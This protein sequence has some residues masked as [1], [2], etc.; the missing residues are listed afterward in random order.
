MVDTFTIFR[1]GMNGAITHSMSISPQQ[2]IAN[3]QVKIAQLRNA[4]AEAEATLKGMEAIYSVTVTTRRRS[5]TTG[6]SGTGE[7]STGGGRQPGAISRRWRAILGE[8]YKEEEGFTPQDTVDLVL[9]LEGRAMKPSEARRL[10]EGYEDHG[11]VARNAAG[12]L[13]I[14][15]DAVRRF[16][17]V[18][19]TKV[20]E[21]PMSPVSNVEVTPAVEAPPPP[22]DRSPPSWPPIGHELPAHS[23]DV[24]SASQWKGAGRTPPIKFGGEDED[25]K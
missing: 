25:D 24:I 2:M 5:N 7:P 17:F 6:G 18:K 12:R 16:G 19:D 23:P 20:S 8:L 11:Y 4:L 9:K 22:H 15:Q 3:Q 21:L 1:G 13:F 10:L 14:S